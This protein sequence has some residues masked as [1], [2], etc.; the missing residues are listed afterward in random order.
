MP[1]RLSFIQA[2][3]HCCFIWSDSICNVKVS[4][5]PKGLVTSR[6]APKTEMFRTTQLIELLSNAITPAFRVR[7]RTVFRLSDIAGGL[8]AA[9]FKKIQH[10]ESSSPSAR[11]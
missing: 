5:T 4:G 8:D 10:Y 9:A 6:H 11:S 7:S 3:W 1:I 2:T